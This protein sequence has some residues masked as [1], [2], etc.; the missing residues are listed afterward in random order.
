[1]VCKNSLISVNLKVHVIP[2]TLFAMSM[3]KCVHL[4][5]GNDEIEALTLFILM[6]SI[7]KIHHD[8]S[9]SI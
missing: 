7:N 9:Q 2:W 1:M 4:S 6:V 5:W 8:I 3:L